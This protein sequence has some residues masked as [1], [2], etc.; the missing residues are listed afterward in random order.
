[1]KTKVSPRPLDISVEDGDITIIQTETGNFF[2]RTR[3]SIISNS[4]LVDRRE[5]N[6][7]IRAAIWI[8]NEVDGN[9]K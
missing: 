9:N 2:I 3:D 1:M 6:S 5:L 4:I 8:K 7:L